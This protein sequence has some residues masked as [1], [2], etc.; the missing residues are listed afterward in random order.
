M[1]KNKI[2]PYRRAALAASE[3]LRNN[4]NNSKAARTANGSAL[5]RRQISTKKVKTS[6]AVA[7]ALSNIRFNKAAQ[8]SA[9]STLIRK[10]RLKKTNHNH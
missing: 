8:I 4:P 2:M 5:S 1:L 9:E 10:S 6:N 3:I 7:K